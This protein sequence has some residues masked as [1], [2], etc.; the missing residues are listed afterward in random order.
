MARQYRVNERIQTPR[1]RVIG[2]NSEQ[3]G[4]MTR[5]QALQMARENDVDLVEVAPNADPPVCRL[6]DYGKLRYLYAKREKESKKGQKSTELREVRFRPNIGV[7]DLDAKIRKV[8]ELIVE[9]GAKVKITV[10]FRGREA[11]HQQL[12][13]SVLKKVADE[14]KDDVRLE[15]A[16]AMEGRSLAMT[17]L[18]VPKRTE[19][20]EK[21][22]KKAEEEDLADAKT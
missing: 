5:D 3:L 14:L 19:R 8:R 6:L 18:P 11:V 21:P 22:E 12:G 17:L 7:H 10:R 4:V 15:K 16:P 13:L 1:V 2:E 9:D 20:A